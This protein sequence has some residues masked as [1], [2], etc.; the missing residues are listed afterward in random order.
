MRLSKQGITL[1]SVALTVAAMLWAAAADAQEAGRLYGVKIEK[2]DIVARLLDVGSLQV[3]QLG[4]LGKAEDQRISGLYQSPDRSIG[5]LGISTKL[6]SDHRSLINVIGIP[7]LL[8][9]VASALI[10]DLPSAYVLSSIAVPP[11]GMPLALVTHYSDTPPFWLANLDPTL[12]RVTILDFPLPPERGY[13]HLTQCPNGSFYAVSSAP[14]WDVRLVQFDLA[15]RALIPLQAF[16]LDGEPLH[17]TIEDLAC[18]PSGELYALS[19]ID[20][21][22]VATLL[23]VDIATGKMAAVTKFEVERMTFVR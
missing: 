11:T 7:E 17:T 18:A 5:L 22:G 15:R 14:Q 3:Q 12:T 23:R 8:A 19:D 2:K 16:T 6:K 20:R 10:G 1:K 13:G 9:D 4:K 21:S